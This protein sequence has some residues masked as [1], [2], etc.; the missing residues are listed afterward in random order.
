MSNG[1]K[2]QNMSLN[3]QNSYNSVPFCAKNGFLRGVKKLTKEEK[4]LELN[5]GKMAGLDAK[6][7]G[8][9][10]CREIIIRETLSGN[11]DFVK[12]FNEIIGNDMAKKAYDSIPKR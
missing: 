8:I 7:R 6:K 12:G 10:E 5:R 1:Q 4:M 9:E 3:I 11:F 2:G